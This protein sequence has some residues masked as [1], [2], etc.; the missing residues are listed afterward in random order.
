M[1]AQGH[2]PLDFHKYSASGW[3]NEHS[4]VGISDISIALINLNQAEPSSFLLS[5]IRS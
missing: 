2:L 3:H 1:A 4:K 5:Y